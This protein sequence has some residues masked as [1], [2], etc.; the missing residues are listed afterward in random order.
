MSADSIH[1]LVDHLF[2]HEAGRMV[3]A[4]TRSFGPA[5]LGLAEEVV[6]EALIQALRRWPFHGIPDKPGAW[7]YRVA[8]NLALDRL[9][10]DATFRDKE[11]SIRHTLQHESDL[12][13]PRAH[14]DDEVSDDQLR[15]VFLC[16]HPEVPLDARVALTLKTVGGFSVPEIA[17]AFLAQP[18]TVAQRLVRAQRRI[19]DR[20]IPFE[21]P[22]GAE[23]ESRLDA[24]LEVLYLLFNEG[25][26]TSGGDE[27][28][29]SDLCAES[30]RLV[31]HLASLPIT[32]RPAV[33]ALH[34]LLLFQASRLP[35]RVDAQGNLVRL[36]QQDRRLWH[37]GLVQK[38]FEAL[39]RATTGQQ[40][41]PYH[42]QA[43]IAAHHA[44]ASGD[45]DTDWRT[46]L[47]LYDRLHAINPSPIVALNRAVAVARVHGPRQGLEALREIES[48]RAVR[49]YYL[50]GAIRG[51]LHTEL[52]ELDAAAAAYRLALDCPCNAPERRFLEGQLRSLRAETA[53]PTDVP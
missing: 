21:L 45:G 16:C 11:D 27:L 38:A 35:A 4:L 22:A 48:H 5:H 41:S 40:Q 32:A 24:V 46:I 34:A 1:G 44:V 14:L 37:R 10:R 51:E 49:K 18:T 33:F 31:E 36:P 3:A 50:L 6:Q 28:V 53:P 9:R 25:Y 29:R 7:L 52:G 12:G 30:L 26:A 47:E 23:L 8:R 2:R 39:R 15:L 17:R 19:R 20:R 42:L 43:A 13:I